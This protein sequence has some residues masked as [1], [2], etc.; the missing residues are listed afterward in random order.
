[1]TLCT[2]KCLPSPRTKDQEQH[3][4]CTYL[5]RFPRQMLWVALTSPWAEEFGKRLDLFKHTWRESRGFSMDSRQKPA[6]G[7][8]HCAVPDW[9]WLTWHSLRKNKRVSVYML[10][11]LNCHPWQFTL[12]VCYFIATSS[13][14]R[15]TIGPD[16][17]NP[18]LWSFMVQ[19]I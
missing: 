12:T 1:M 8:W 14:I 15:K 6:W 11:R 17:L 3:R 9:G 10:R 13:D 5:L 18:V 19:T 7:M 2:W 4:N 16:L